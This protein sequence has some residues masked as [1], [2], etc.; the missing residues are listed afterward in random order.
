MVTQPPS[1]PSTPSTLSDPQ[2]FWNAFKLYE[3][4]LKESAIAT[5]DQFPIVLK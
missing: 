4:F 5:S 2:S 1:T 3:A